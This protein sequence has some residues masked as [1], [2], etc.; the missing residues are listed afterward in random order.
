MPY[1]IADTP[2]P[3]STELQTTVELPRRKTPDLCT[4]AYTTCTLLP[5]EQ[6]AA[7]MPDDA[8][9]ASNVI[10]VNRVRV[11]TTDCRLH[12]GTMIFGSDGY[13][14][15]A[16][17]SGGD[18][19]SSVGEFFVANAHSEVG[20]GV[21]LHAGFVYGAMALQQPY[22]YTAVWSGTPGSGFPG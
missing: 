20:Q 10:T 19:N 8:G 13:C 7:F 15:P 16:M 6:S 17:C 12:T 4:N 22:V 5:V 11:A 3:Y 14:R 1:T 9:I 2:Y 21:R 18:V